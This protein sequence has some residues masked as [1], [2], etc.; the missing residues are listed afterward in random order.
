MTETQAFW[1]LVDVYGLCTMDATYLA[2]ELPEDFE[3]W[4]EGGAKIHL[5]MLAEDF[6]AM[7]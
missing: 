6:L 4:G 7:A 2:G 1:Y 5:S 3:K